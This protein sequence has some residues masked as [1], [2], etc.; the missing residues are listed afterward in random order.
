MEREMSQQSVVEGEELRSRINDATSDTSDNESKLKPGLNSSSVIETDFAELE[1]G[2]LVE[3]I[4]D[5]ENSSNTLFV[6]FDGKEAH[7]AHEVEY[8]SKLLVPI[9]RNGK[10][11]RHVRLPQGVKPYGSA[12]SLLE[13]LDSIF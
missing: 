5:P 13:Q 11:I 8:K 2:S 9:L 1:D 4:E 3:L 12:D 10:I 6:I 7:F